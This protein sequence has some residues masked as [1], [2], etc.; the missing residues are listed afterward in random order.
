MEVKIDLQT[1]LQLKDILDKLMNKSSASLDL[2]N[3]SVRFQVD[4]IRQKVE[5]AILKI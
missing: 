1:A 5:E 4:N 3:F 2:G